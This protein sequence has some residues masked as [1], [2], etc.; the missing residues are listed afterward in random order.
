MAYTSERV[1]ELNLLL[2]FDLESG[3]QGLKIHKSAAPAVIAA[4]ERLH[5]KGL[6][7]QVDGGYL[8]AH[9]RQVAEQASAVITVLENGTV[10]A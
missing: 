7:T 10:A 3:Q 1:D 4:A 8:T 6:T 5:R 2:R 9:G